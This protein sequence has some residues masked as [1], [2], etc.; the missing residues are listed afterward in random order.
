MTRN[1]AYQGKSTSM[2]RKSKD[3]TKLAQQR[4]QQKPTAAHQSLAYL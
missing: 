3:D 1:N 2:E 4:D